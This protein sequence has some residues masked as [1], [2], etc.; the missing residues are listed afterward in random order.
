MVCDAKALYNRLNWKCKNVSAKLMFVN[1]WERKV[2]AAV[3]KVMGST[4]AGE[5]ETTIIIFAHF[6][7]FA[8]SG[9]QITENVEKANLKQCCG[10]C[11]SS[12]QALSSS[13][14]LAP[15]RRSSTLSSS[16]TPDVV[17]VV[18]VVADDDGRPP[19]SM[20][21]CCENLSAKRSRKTSSG[22]LGSDEQIW[23]ELADR[24]E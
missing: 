1:R 4:P 8:N 22:G 7:A 20:W 6:F 11:L 24:A 10:R 19:T 5:G 18:V 21:G 9:N 16:S 14:S 2:Y 17:V 23:A 12:T 13:S 15:P 3:W